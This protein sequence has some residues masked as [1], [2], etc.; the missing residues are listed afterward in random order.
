MKKNQLYLLSIIVFFVLIAAIIFK[1]NVSKIEDENKIYSLLER[2]GTAANSEEWKQTK[3]KANSFLAAINRDPLDKKSQLGLAALFIQEA[4]ISG[5]YAYYDQAAMKT[6]NDVLRIDSNNFEALV[7]QSLIYYSQHHFAEGLATAEKA[8]NINPYN[9]YVYGLMIDGNVEMGNYDSAIVNADRMVAIRPDL[10]SYSRISYIREIHG[11]YKGAIEAM[12]LAVEAGGPGDEYTE[13]S[14]V[15]L[16]SLLEKTGD[17]MNA[18]MLYN[19]SLNLRPDY[20]FAIAGLGRMQIAKK[21]YDSA[22]VYFKKANGLIDDNGIKE[23]L[24]DAYRLAGK[25]NESKKMAE[26]IIYELSLNAEA[27]N[28]DESIGHYADRELAYA[29]LKAGDKDKALEHALFEY[30][31]RPQNIDVNETVAWVYYN[32]GEIEKALPYIKTAMKT[33]SKNPV[34]INRAALIFYKAGEKD[35]AK[36]LIAQTAAINSHIDPIL[37]AETLSVMQ[38]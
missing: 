2:K 26:A 33:N 5:D 32:R 9:A 36:S 13:W 19:I 31:R 34:F 21:Q 4:R 25:N 24:A 30:N 11:D 37:Q 17:Y 23:S 29:Y 35:L 10:T 15:Q 8:K 1:Y 3:E 16:A 12:K 6:I 27:G 22:V 18:E 7:Y 28:K 20:P 14:R 38:N